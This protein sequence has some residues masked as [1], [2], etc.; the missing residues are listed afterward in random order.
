MDFAIEKIGPIE[1][2]GILKGNLGN[3]SIIE[4]HVQNLADQMSSGLWKQSLDPIRISK[5]GRLL[6][7]QHRLLA[8]LTSKETIEFLVV[9]GLDEEVFDVLDTGKHRSAADAAHI[10]GIPQSKPCSALAKL[11]MA[12]EKDPKQTF[13]ISNLIKIKT[14]ED[15]RKL[16]ISNQTVV[17]FIKKNLQE[18]LPALR[19]GDSLFSKGRILS[20]TEYA[21]YY[22]IFN[23]I[24]TED[25]NLFCTKLA[26]GAEL[27]EDSPIY[28]IR[29]RLIEHLGAPAKLNRTYK[30]LAIT[31]AWNL[32]R[33]GKKCKNLKVNSE[34]KFEKL[35]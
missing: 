28:A 17:A 13:S 2:D 25:A 12:F 3:R 5:N 29:K 1:A 22:L 35:V 21:F 26:S 9:R 31:Y 32:F 27:E 19:I 14:K 4:N 23:R 34:M 30:F 6:D 15:P 24:D 8:V 33:L 18:I 10:L 11:L 20:K 16:I 7:G